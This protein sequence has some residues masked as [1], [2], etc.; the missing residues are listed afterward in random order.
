LIDDERK[1]FFWI[2]QMIG[3]LVVVVVGEVWAGQ[4]D[5]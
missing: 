3:G 1:C 2:Q 5:E 4:V